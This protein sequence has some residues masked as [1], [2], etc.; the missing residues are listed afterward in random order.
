[1]AIG[2]AQGTKVDVLQAGA[3]LLSGEYFTT[4]DPVQF[5]ERLIRAY[6]VQDPEELPPFEG[7]L[8]VGYQYIS[9]MMQPIGAQPFTL[10]IYAYRC[11]D[12]WLEYGGPMIT[13][14]P[15]AHFYEGCNWNI[16]VVSLPGRNGK[17]FGEHMV[18]LAQ[19]KALALIE[20]RHTAPGPL[21]YTDYAALMLEPVAGMI[22]SGSIS[23]LRH[24]GDGEM[25]SYLYRL[26]KGGREE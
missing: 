5:A 12:K 7:Y 13:G 19:G 17:E 16:P 20:T 11:Y 9:L 6:E 21:A 15:G 2:I 10:C 14:D 4:K 18:V 26:E 22:A 1:M 25:Y 24:H 3:L 23:L 8:R